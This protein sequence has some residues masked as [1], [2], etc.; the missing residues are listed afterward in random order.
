MNKGFHFNTQYHLVELLGMKAKNPAELLDGI[1]SVP[2]SSIYYHTHRF[3]Q[4][5]H[6]L[7]PEAPNDF[8]FWLKDILHLER[9]GEAFL[10]VDTIHF[11]NLEHLRKTFQTILN[12]HIFQGEAVIDC[13]PGYEFHFM[14]SKIFVLPTRYTANNLLEFADILQKVSIHSLYFHMFEAR[15]RLGV[16]DNDFSAW[17]RSIKEERLADEISRLDPYNM[18]LENLRKKII[19]MVE[20]RVQDR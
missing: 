11:S 17:L 12:N 8:A 19:T 10:G 16:P 3:L 18:T 13:L 1:E 5:H 7:S 2:A 14:A 4:Q 15:M 20:S 9:L 6:H